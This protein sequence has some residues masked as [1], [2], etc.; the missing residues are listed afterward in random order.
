M[1]NALSGV[2]FF[3][4]FKLA[5]AKLCNNSA[6]YCVTNRETFFLCRFSQ[7]KFHTRA[8]LSKH[9]TCRTRSLPAAPVKIF[10]EGFG[11]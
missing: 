5:H 8:S 6:V 4:L 3:R 10:D 2:Y 11:K 1:T 7:V 9:T